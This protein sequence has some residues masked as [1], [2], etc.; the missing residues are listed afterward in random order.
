MNDIIE[1]IFVINLEKC[2][3][4]K[5]HIIKEFKNYNIQNYEFFK[6]TNA[7][8]EIVKD[9]MTNGFVKKSETRC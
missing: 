7:D 3:D 5:E 8:S 6:A 9:M 2:I 4:R 1:K